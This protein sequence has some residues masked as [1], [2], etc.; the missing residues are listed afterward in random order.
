MS[1]QYEKLV[2]LLKVLFQTDQA[3]LDFGIYRIMNQRREE[4]N[5][6]LEEDLLSQVKEALSTYQ[7]ADQS[8]LQA[9]LK[10]AIQ[11]AKELDVDPDSVSKVKEIR[12]KLATY[13]ENVGDVENQVY[14]DLYQFF[15]RYYDDG[16]F[17]SQ[18]RYKD[19]VY[20]IPY[21][22][23]EVK[24]YWANYDQYYIKTSEYLRD[25]TF[26]VPS[27]KKVHFKLVEADTEKDNR[28]ENNEKKRV[29]ILVEDAIH[30]E[31]AEVQICFEFRAD[32]EKRTQ[33]QLNEITI[34]AIFG[35]RENMDDPII[36]E[37]L[38]ELATPSP[39]ASDKNRTLL[40]KHL[41][42]YTRRNTQDYFIHKDLG[43]FLRR[44]LDFYIKNEIM[45]LDDI[46][47]ASAPR[48]EQ[49]LSRV[50]VLRQIAHKII[51]FLAQIEDFQK[52]LWLK[53]KF[54]V[55]TNYC[56]T[57]DRIPEE[58]YPE[59]AANEMQREEWVR[60][61]A[62]DE[63]RACPGNLLEQGTPAY[64]VPLTVE[65]LKANPFL[66]LDTKYF[67]NKFKIRLFESIDD[68][69]EMING[70]LVQ[71]EN[72]QTLNLLNNKYKDKVKAIYIDPPYNTGTD[73][74][75]CYKDLYKNSTWL[76]MLLDRLYL[77]SK[78]L[79]SSGLLACHI[80]ENEHLSL[81]W[82]IKKIFGT[83]GDLG[84]LIWDKRNPKGDANGIST[85]HEYIHFATSNLNHLLEN[86]Y[87]FV[88]NKENAETILEKAHQ[89]IS[90]AGTVSERVCRE[91]RDWISGQDFSGG[92]KAYCFIDNKGKVFQSVSMAW[93]NKKKAPDEYFVPLKHPKTGKDCPLPSRGWRNS[94]DT[95]KELLRKDLI[96]FGEDES[97]Q[98]RRKYYLEENLTESVASLYYMGGSDDAFFDSIDLHFENPKP[99]KIAKYILSIVG[100]D[101]ESIIID[102]FAGSGTTA[103]ALINLNREDGGKR[104]YILVEMGEYFD[105][106]LKPRIQKVIY[107]E[108]WKN[109]K[110]VSRKGS[111]HAFKYI[112]LE[113]Y[114]DTLNN[115]QLK[116]SEEQN[117]SLLTE[118]AF[119]EDYMLHYMLDVE[120]CDSL[121]DLKIFETPFD[122]HL[123]IATSTVGE[124]V[125]TKVDLVETFNYLIGLCVK[126]I[127][128]VSDCVLVEGTCE[129]DGR[130]LVI[131]RDLRKTDNKKLES[132]FREW[133]IVER[134]DAPEVIYVNGDNTLMTLR[135]E[136][137][138]WRVKLIEEEFHRRMFEDSN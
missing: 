136:E 86:D 111:S 35:A 73:D 32:E 54:V 67:D 31:K 30:V 49:Y 26:K 130:V 133:K 1:A 100:R 18:R 108:D 44:E 11:K 78:F 119:K 59:I 124:T 23:E 93:P 76:T 79:N 113:S 16:D 43:K 94:P 107:S 17:I 72:Y 77:S 55:E 58:L 135:K 3:D 70:L 51:D 123:N 122:Y 60:L 36:K 61:F 92:E 64:S 106:V 8:I 28:K 13:G 117:A 103:H 52:K 34:K 110:P 95:M 25:Y 114:E 84:E 132:L 118:E 12:E 128:Y 89:L 85:Q 98:P 57:L 14:N 2:Q 112:K 129:Q 65:F 42:D 115:L 137:Q 121:L 134:E 39:T 125:P 91:F 21:E 66:L 37:V 29:F 22:G 68:M 71:G 96:L 83:Q 27:G 104:K 131:W 53:K 48:V 62:I 90:S 4:I 69:D 20:A 82:V 24:L 126:S 19:G 6:F 41:E 105:T 45:R 81:E 116:R 127:R 102:Y 138:S 15:R 87:A 75:F 109:G 99:V 101:E 120:A 80:D 56:I 5:R 9:D 74:N 88:K 7:S 33:K 63:I 40:A 97:T 38:A 10:E 50:K 47:E 46:E